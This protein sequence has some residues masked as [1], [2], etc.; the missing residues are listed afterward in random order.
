MSPG[1]QQLENF[2]KATLSFNGDC[3]E[4]AAQQLEWLRLAKEQT[5]EKQAISNI[6]I[7]MPASVE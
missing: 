3:A 1:S 5:A 2:K 6:L 7:Q 4:F